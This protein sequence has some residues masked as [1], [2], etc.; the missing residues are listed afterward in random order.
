[1]SD[2]EIDHAALY[3]GAA[4]ELEQRDASD[5]IRELEADVERLQKENDAWV[6]GFNNHGVDIREITRI[7][8]TLE[9]VWREVNNT[10]IELSWTP[11]KSTGGR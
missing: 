3:C 5:R 6:K 2:Y 1:M 9:Y 8:D 10:A 7:K 11:P 4:S